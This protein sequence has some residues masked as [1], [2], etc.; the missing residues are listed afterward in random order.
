M[1]LISLQTEYCISE[2]FW[3]SKTTLTSKK[4]FLLSFSALTTGDKRKEILYLYI[5]DNSFSVVAI[6]IK[7]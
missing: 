1:E 5:A 3:A 7:E 4:L 2:L 6:V